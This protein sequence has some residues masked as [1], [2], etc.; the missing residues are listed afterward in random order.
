MHL[1]YFELNVREIW[2]TIIN[3]LNV[4]HVV[5]TKYVYDLL[6]TTAYNYNVVFRV[7]IDMIFF[8]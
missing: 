2:F 1:L 6:L 4:N 7:V 3:G 8:V 5:T